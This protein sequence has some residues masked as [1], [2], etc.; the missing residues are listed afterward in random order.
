MNNYPYSTQKKPRKQQNKHSPEKHPAKNGERQIKVDIKR[1]LKQHGIDK[2]AA[3]SR[4][5][6]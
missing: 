6:S 3:L 5:W 1:A 2:R 4:N